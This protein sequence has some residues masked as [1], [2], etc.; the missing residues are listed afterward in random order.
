MLQR[1]LVTFAQV[2]AGN[3]SEKLLNEITQI[4]HFWCWAKEISEKSI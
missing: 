4:I 1:L 2:I 3:P